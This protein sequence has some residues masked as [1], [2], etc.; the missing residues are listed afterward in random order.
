MYYGQGSPVG[1]NLDKIL[2]L[3]SVQ[4]LSISNYCK[5]SMFCATVDLCDMQA[6]LTPF[7]HSIDIHSAYIVDVSDA[8]A[9]RFGM[10]AGSCLSIL[11]TGRIVSAG[12]AVALA[13]LG[14]HGVLIWQYSSF[15]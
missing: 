3:E 10:T 2:A 13:N 1:S 8:R 4:L 15:E 6:L 14:G 12:V 9:R 5:R 7:L 11:E